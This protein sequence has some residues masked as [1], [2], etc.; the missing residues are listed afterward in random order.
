MESQRQLGKL[1]RVVLSYA[2]QKNYSIKVQFKDFLFEGNITKE[3]LSHDFS[4]FA[5]L[6]SL[7]FDDI[8]LYSDIAE[9]IVNCFQFLSMPDYIITVKQVILNKVRGATIDQLNAMSDC[10]I[11]MFILNKAY[12]VS[13]DRIKVLEKLYASI[14]YILSKLDLKELKR[15]VNK[16]SYLAV[17]RRTYLPRIS[18]DIE[19]ERL[20]K[21]TI[22]LDQIYSNQELENKFN[23]FK[24]MI[25]TV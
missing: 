3:A 23:E 6:A 10:D 19:I 15:V 5:A 12:N 20:T 21:Q 16:E 17:L 18:T 7:G 22:L 4:H 8:D 14:E 2:D 13:E 11:L 9:V 24:D 1:E 25:K